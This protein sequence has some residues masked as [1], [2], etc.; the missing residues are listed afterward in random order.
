MIHTSRVNNCIISLLI[1]ISVNISPAYA[2]PNINGAFNSDFSSVKE[3]YFDAYNWDSNSISAYEWNVSYDG[4]DT[5]LQRKTGFQKEFL[6]DN[7][8]TT[9]KFL[10]YSTDDMGGDNIV[11]VALGELGKEDSLETP[12]Y[13]NN[14]KYNSWFYRR[15]VAGEAYPWCCAFVAWCA[16]KCGYTEESTGSIYTY[17]GLF[18]R[19]AGCADMYNH[20]VN[21]RGFD[22][23][24]TTSCTTFGG[25]A[26]QP[27]PGD[28]LF[29]IDDDGSYGHIGIIVDTDDTHLYVVEGNTT[30]SLSDSPTPG[31]GVA[32]NVYRKGSSSRV[33]RGYIVHVKYPDPAK[34]IYN[35]LTGELGY[36]SAAACGVLANIECESGFQADIEEVGTGIG[37]GL[38]QWSFGRRT[39]LENWCSSNGYDYK[40]ITGQLWYLKYELESSYTTVHNALLSVSNDAQGAY[41]AGHRWCYS[42]EIPQNYQSVSITRG[43]LART[44]YWPLYSSTS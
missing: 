37:Y 36:N 30:G 40:T 21:N 11:A 4:V 13:S 10:G 28:I 2:L 26:Y 17:G 25:S 34:T 33:D 20:L 16:Y 43:N 9:L 32:K 3:Q 8:E 22:S 5:T 18:A 19:T 7:K 14:V 15:D 44:K 31:G 1:V 38:C 24:T 6:A 29:F 42:F 35:F 39:R 23:Y 41:D 27:V 12:A